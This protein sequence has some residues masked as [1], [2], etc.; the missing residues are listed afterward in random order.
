MNKTLTGAVVA[1]GVTIASATGAFAQAC[2]DADAVAEALEQNYGEVVT[3]SFEHFE[4]GVLVDTH[5]L[6]ENEETGTWTAI[7]NHG[8]E[9]CLLADGDAST[10]GM[11]PT[12]DQW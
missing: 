3:D 9:R 4:N 11:V 2:G 7:I 12:P 1:A 5:E 10:R 6:F 8:E